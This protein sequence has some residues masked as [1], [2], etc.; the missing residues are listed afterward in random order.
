MPTNF[1]RSPT[2]NTSCKRARRLLDIIGVHP[3]LVIARTKA[4]LREELCPMELI[5]ELIDDRDGEGI[6]DGEGGEG[7]VDDA[8]HQEPSAFLTSRTGEENEEELR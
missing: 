3:D 2:W 7:A 8:E 4:E 5:Q 1:L 6:F